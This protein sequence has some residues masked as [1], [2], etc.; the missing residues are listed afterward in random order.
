M[1]PEI[2]DHDKIVAAQN[3]W[4]K[5]FKLGDR[6][7]EI[8]DLGYFDYIEFMSLAKP[9][10]KLAAGALEMDNAGG[11]LKADFNPAALDMDEVIKLCGK[12]LPRMGQLICKQ[13]DPKIKAEEVAILAHRP[14]RLV[15]LVLMQILHNNMIQEFASFFTR[16]TAMVTV[17]M[18][19][20][21]KAAT[22]SEIQS[23]S[24]IAET[25]S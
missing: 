18:P 10:I 24:A 11:E 4:G 17:M 13:T 9:I 15:E 6:E 12:E 5:T 19:D 23:E 3:E 14:Q 2:T 25:L 8:K 7:F 1:T 21:A 20:L 22:P 16:L